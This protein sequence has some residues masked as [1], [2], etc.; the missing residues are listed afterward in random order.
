MPELRQGPSLLHLSPEGKVPCP[1]PIQ[2][3]RETAN[4]SRPLSFTHAYTEESPDLIRLAAASGGPFLSLNSGE[5]CQ[6]GQI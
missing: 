1:H 5:F 4:V 3:E 6:S 2:R